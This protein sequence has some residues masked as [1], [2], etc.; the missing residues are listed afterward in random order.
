MRFPFVWRK[1][2]EADKAEALRKAKASHDAHI[3]ALIQAAKVERER[4][5]REW[6]GKAT[7]IL[8]RMIDMSAERNYK[9]DF[10][11]HFALDRTMLETACGNDPTLWRYIAEMTGRHI[12]RELATMNFAGLHRLAAEYERRDRRRAVYQLPPVSFGDIP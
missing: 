2:A 7:P 6:D 1:T 8:R 10:M 3:G 4:K 5:Q 11:L 9:D 12:E